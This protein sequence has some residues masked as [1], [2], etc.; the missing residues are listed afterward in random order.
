MYYVLYKQLRSDPDKM[1]NNELILVLVDCNAENG[2]TY[3]L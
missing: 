3:I 2:L 1:E